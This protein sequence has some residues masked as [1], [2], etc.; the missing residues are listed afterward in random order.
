MPALS[1]QGYTPGAVMEL[2]TFLRMGTASIGIRLSGKKIVTSAAAR[3]SALE[4]SASQD[5]WPLP[6]WKGGAAR[7]SLE[8]LKH[9]IRS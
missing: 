8:R 6:P 2:P 9:S 3:E 7:C 5:P 1:P 4:L